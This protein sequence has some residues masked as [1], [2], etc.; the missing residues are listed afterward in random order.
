[1]DPIME[2][3]TALVQVVSENPFATAF[4]ASVLRNATG[5]LCNRFK[6]GA[7][8]DKDQFLATLVKFEVAVP[9]LSVFLPTEYAAA[10]VVLGDIIGSWAAKLRS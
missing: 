2:V 1:M 3:G 8:Y 4:L 5:Y 10:A 7:K 9:A 6:L